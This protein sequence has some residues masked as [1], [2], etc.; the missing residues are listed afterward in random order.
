MKSEEEKKYKEKERKTIME[1]TFKIL[2]LLP[3]TMTQSLII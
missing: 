3:K 1:S 2:S